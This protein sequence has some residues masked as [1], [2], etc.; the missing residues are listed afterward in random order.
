MINNKN[1]LFK[2][3]AIIRPII[4]NNNPRI[5]A[6]FSEISLEGIGRFFLYGCFLSISESII[7]LKM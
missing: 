7:S 5:I 6:N 2:L 4:K 1:N 3:I